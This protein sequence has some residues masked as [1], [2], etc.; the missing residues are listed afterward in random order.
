MAERVEKREWIME[1]E[2]ATKGGRRVEPW[3]EPYIYS[4]CCRDYEAKRR[5]RHSGW[6][7]K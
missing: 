1:E 4:G 5:R 3:V 6:R 7:I 2:E